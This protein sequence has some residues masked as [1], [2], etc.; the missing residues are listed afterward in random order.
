M[1]VEIS[2]L[3]GT[4][5]ERTVAEAISSGW[6]QSEVDAALQGKVIH[7]RGTRRVLRRDDGTWPTIE[8]VLARRRQERIDEGGPA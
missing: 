1:L 6:T 8:K 3:T 7:D 4:V 2:S 5:F